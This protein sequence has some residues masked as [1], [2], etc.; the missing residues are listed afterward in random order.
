MLENLSFASRFS[1][2]GREGAMQFNFRGIIAAL[3]LCWGVI[4]CGENILEAVSNRSTDAAYLERARI[5]LDAGDFAGAI[6]AISAMSGPAQAEREAKNLLA[7]A[8]AGR[9]G[10]TFFKLTE[11]L[12]DMT[13]NLFLELMRGYP[14]AT[15]IEVA[16]CVA[17]ETILNSFG[18]VSERT[19]S[20]NLLMVLI[21]FAKIG[22]ILSKDADGDADG[23]V[24]GTFDHCTTSTDDDVKQIVTGLGNLLVS[25]PA[26]GSSLGGSSANDIATLCGSLPAQQN[27]CQVQKID[28]VTADH[29]LAMRGLVGTQDPPGLGSCAKDLINCVADC[30]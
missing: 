10:M 30:P 5:R 29:I 27:F 4:G 20:E 14:G 26:A 2:R 17:A 23:A 3:A 28:D 19:A 13:D 9:C 15:A 18:G 1:K 12:S 16:D 22:T 6:S 7:S 11:T 24:D 21:S 25:L 8:Y